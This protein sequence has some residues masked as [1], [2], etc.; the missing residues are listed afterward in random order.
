MMHYLWGNYGWDGV[1]QG[2]G[3]LGIWGLTGGILMLVFMIA[4][5]ALIIWGLVVFIRWISDQARH[6]GR[7]G[8]NETPLE[9]LKERYAKGE[10]NK[11]EFEEIKKD[12]M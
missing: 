7:A 2:G 4:F 12:L 6:G 10:I 11:K 9:I 8:K 5:W 3:T 1:Y